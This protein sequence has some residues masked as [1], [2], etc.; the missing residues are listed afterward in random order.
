M[1]S[2]RRRPSC[3]VDRAVSAAEL[4][5]ALSVASRR[6]HGPCPYLPP[7]V[8]LWWSHLLQRC[9]DVRVCSAEGGGSWGQA[10]RRGPKAATV[11]M[12]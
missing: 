1:L 12:A 2:H 6:P 5:P 8:V 4:M 11:R 7:L 10:R 3:R 9:A